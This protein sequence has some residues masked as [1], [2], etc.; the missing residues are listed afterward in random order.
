MPLCLRARLDLASN[1]Q[2]CSL[3]VLNLREEVGRETL[4]QSFRSEVSSKGEYYYYL[5]FCSVRSGVMF[6]F[7]CL[8]RRL[9]ISLRDI[10]I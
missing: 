4:A 9:K 5:Y 7:L 6:G 10:I 2:K 3:H 8:H 1:L